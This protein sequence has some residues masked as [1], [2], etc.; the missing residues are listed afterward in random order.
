MTCRQGTYCLYLDSVCLWCET[1]HLKRNAEKCCIMTFTNK[2]KHLSFDYAI[3]SKSQPR[4][5]AVKDLGFTLIGN[6][7]F[8]DHISRNVSKALKM[9][10]F[11][12][13]VCTPF[14]DVQTLRSLCI[15]LVRSQLEYCSAIW[16]PLQHTFIDKIEHVPK[17]CINYLCYKSKIPYSTENYPALC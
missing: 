9:C 14:T 1:W 13:R 5:I 3:L 11:V 2:K 7:K 8:K 4:V 15:S 17:K 16:N 6:L 10:G 12:K